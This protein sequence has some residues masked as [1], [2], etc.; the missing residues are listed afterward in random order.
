MHLDLIVLVVLA[1]LAIWTEV[2]KL[3]APGAAQQ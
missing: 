3:R 1:G 2:D